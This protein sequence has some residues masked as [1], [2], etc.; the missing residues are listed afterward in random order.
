MTDARADSIALRDAEADDLVSV[1]TIYNHYVLHSTC[2]FATDPPDAPYWQ[3]WLESHRAP[4]AAI[5]AVRG[6]E[7]VG[8]GSLSQ[9]NSRCA[10]RYTVEDSVYVRHDCHGRGIGSR[11][12]AEL[13]RIA[14]EKGH[15]TILAQI[16]DD[17][18]RSKTLH[19]RHGFR[20][21]GVLR[22]VGYKFGRWLD[23]GM[24][25]WR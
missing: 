2:T 5:V 13:I 10:Y 20:L 15:R 19:E 16:A 9:W 8:W 6:T 17:Q 11:L 12:L 23:V 7:V 25:Q 3:A 14:V 18:E 4:F 21:A 24:W 22:A 1:S